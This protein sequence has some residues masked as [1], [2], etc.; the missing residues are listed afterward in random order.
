MHKTF[1]KIVFKDPLEEKEIVIHCK[2]IGPCVYEIEV[3]EGDS[4]IYYQN[5][6]DYNDVVGVIAFYKREVN[7]I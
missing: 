7:S 6:A 1:W 5:N 2:L 3:C 4:L